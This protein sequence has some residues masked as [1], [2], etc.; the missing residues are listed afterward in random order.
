MALS[1]PIKI[2]PL[3]YFLIGY[4]LDLKIGDL[5]CLTYTSW[6]FRI[7][8]ALVRPLEHTP[9]LIRAILQS[10]QIYHATD[11]LEFLG[12]VK[13]V[14]P[15]SFYLF[16]WGISFQTGNLIITKDDTNKIN[17]TFK[18]PNWYCGNRRYRTIVGLTIL[19]FNLF[20]LPSPNLVA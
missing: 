4:R 9:H 11:F 5:F 18:R 7:T 14:I 3:S 6:T 10:F 16:A 15:D 20:I 2:D 13:W 12:K 1:Y 19:T 8:S 17:G